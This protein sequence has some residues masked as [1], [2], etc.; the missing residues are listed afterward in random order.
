MPHVQLY[1]MGGQRYSIDTY[2]MGK[3]GA[4]L[5][6]WVPIL[7]WD[8]MARQCI[9]MEVYPLPLPGTGKPDLLLPENTRLPMNAYGAAEVI[10]TL[11]VVFGLDS[12]ADTAD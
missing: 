2:D 7:A 9:R 1:D 12:D 10:K 8:P 5:Q 3:V 4:W 11:R 6:E